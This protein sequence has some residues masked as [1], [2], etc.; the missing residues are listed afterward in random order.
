MTNRNGHTIPTSIS[1][2]KIDPTELRAMAANL[3]KQYN[4]V[5][6]MLSQLNDST[7]DKN[8]EKYSCEW[9]RHRLQTDRGKTLP[10]ADKEE[11]NLPII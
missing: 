6:R 8:C 4:E 11:R 1:K 2:T 7:E 5:N 3:Q 9:P 10:N